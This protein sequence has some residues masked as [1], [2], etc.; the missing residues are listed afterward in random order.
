VN[1]GTTLAALD[2]LDEAVAA[3]RQAIQLRPDLGAVHFNL[4]LALRDQGKLQE[5]ADSFRKAD[6][7][8]PKQPVIM[9][10]LRQTVSWL[11]FDKKLPAILDGREK[12]R[13]VG[14]QLLF[15]GYCTDYKHLHRTAV[16]FYA[17]GFRTNP[18]AADDRVAQYRYLAARS[19]VLAAAGKGD[20][21]AGLSES[22]RDT[23]RRQ[24]RLWL[25]EDLAVWGRDLDTNPTG[26][27]LAL[28]RAL[29]H[30][31]NDV[32]FV[33]ARDESELAKLPTAESD[34]WRKIWSDVAGLLQ[35]AKT[36]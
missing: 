21:V 30:W 34:A 12:L 20:D 10:N 8:L 31:Q 35:R 29:Q 22:E 24:S 2:R 14:E 5:A 6:A 4:G 33:P 17:D 1:L 36:N 32:A 28:I 18:T 13:D 27:R 3:Y 16:R 25:N 15:A 9:Q 23:L 7:L 26:I 19:A 11:E